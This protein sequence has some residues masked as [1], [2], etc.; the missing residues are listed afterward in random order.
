M[1][2]RAKVA[3]QEVDHNHEIRIDHSLI[4]EIEVSHSIDAR[5]A[6]ITLMLRVRIA[7]RKGKIAKHA[8]KL[9]TLQN[10]AA[11]NR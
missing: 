3:G 2:V 4:S 5:I 10:V 11:L 6:E 9:G 1:R 8:A 7:L